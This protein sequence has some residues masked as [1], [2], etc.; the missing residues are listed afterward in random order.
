MVQAT[1]LFLESVIRY[2]LVPE[3]SDLLLGDLSKVVCEP[4]S[5]HRGQKQTQKNNQVPK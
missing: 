4:T 5:L 2:C 3:I 1:P